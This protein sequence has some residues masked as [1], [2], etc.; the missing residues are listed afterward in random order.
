MKNHGNSLSLWKFNFGRN[1]VS[2]EE[3]SIDLFKVYY[4]D[5]PSESNGKKHGHEMR[6]REDGVFM[7]EFGEGFLVNHAA[8]LAFKLF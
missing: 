1:S 3:K 5:V 7:D 2:R 4:L 6:L 8:D